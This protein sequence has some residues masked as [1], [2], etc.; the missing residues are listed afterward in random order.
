[1]E[2]I[3]SSKGKSIKNLGKKHKLKQFTKFIMKICV[4]GN[5][6]SSD[7]QNC[8]FVFDLFNEY[9]K[10]LFIGKGKCHS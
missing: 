9:N 8:R 6:S 5:I 1:M 3:G 10:L 7:I 4:T 2:M